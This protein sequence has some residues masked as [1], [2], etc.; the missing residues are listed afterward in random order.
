MHFS[1]TRKLKFHAAPTAPHFFKIIETTFWRDFSLTEKVWK[2]CSA[3]PTSRSR[4]KNARN[5]IQKCQRLSTVQRALEREQP[6]MKYLSCKR[7][8]T[9]K[10]KITSRIPFP[11]KKYFFPT[12]CREAVSFGLP[13]SLSPSRLFFAFSLAV[14]R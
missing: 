6:R 1:V 4:E 3:S 14:C 5:A 11:P 9:A 7:V 10:K 12:I 2:I 8:Y 13:P